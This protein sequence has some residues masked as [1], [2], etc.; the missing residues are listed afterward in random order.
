MPP[1]S[2]QFPVLPHQASPL[3]RVCGV[4]EAFGEGAAQ[5]KL[6][7]N[8][9]TFSV[10]GTL[11]GITSADLDDACLEA[12]KRWERVIGVRVDKNPNPKTDATQIVTVANM[13]GPSG[14][15]ADQQLPYGSGM[16]LLMR[17]DSSER[18]T[19]SDAPGPGQINLL[20]VLVHEDGHCLGMQHINADGDPDLMN[21]TYSPSIFRPQEDDIVYGR[22]LYGGPIVVEPA[23]EP[24]LP[25][26]IAATWEARIGT[27]VYRANGI[28]KRV[29]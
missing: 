2:D 6:P 12:W 13:G 19:I 21:P 15:L 4:S 9:I 22:K 5:V 7:S 14:V 10:R 1:T 18:W 27:A 11:P 24:G 20:A 25:K 29:A 17:L 8:R 16:N 28:A 23:P 3:V 26:E